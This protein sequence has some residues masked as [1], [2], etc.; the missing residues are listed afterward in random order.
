M[1]RHRLIDIPPRDLPLCIGTFLN[2]ARAEAGSHEPLTLWRLCRS[3]S[4]DFS[5]IGKTGHLIRS[6]VQKPWHFIKPRQAGVSMAVLGPGEHQPAIQINRLCR[7]SDVAFHFFI[8]ADINN[9]SV[10]YRNC[11][12]KAKFPID[13]CYLSVEKHKICRNRHLFAL[14]LHLLHKNLPFFKNSTKNRQTLTIPYLICCLPVY[15]IC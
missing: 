8:T 5:E 6:H 13:F 14:R 11:S 10:L 7:F 4:E 15:T 2:T 9:P 12:A 1:L 3:L